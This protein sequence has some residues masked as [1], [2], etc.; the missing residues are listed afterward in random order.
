MYVLEYC[1][2]VGETFDIVIEDMIRQANDRR[3]SVFCKKKK[4]QIK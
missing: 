3:E 2:S 1:N 4:K